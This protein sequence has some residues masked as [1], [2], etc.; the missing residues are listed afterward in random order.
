MD[1]GHKNTY[2]TALARNPLF[3]DF[4]KKYC[5]DVIFFLFNHFLLSDFKRGARHPPVY[6]CF[7]V[8]VAQKGGVT[9]L[10]FSPFDSMSGAEKLQMLVLKITLKLQ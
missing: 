8:A 7:V 10:P 9:V 2:T 5:T 3:H 1:N 4:V 6:F